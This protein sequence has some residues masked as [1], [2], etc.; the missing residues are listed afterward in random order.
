MQWHELFP[1]DKTPTTEDISRF[2]GGETA[3]L[4]NELVHTCQQRWKAK[5]KLTYSVC[6][7]KPG[8]NLKLQKSGK[9]LGT[10]YPE[11]GSFS[12]FMVLPFS[13]RESMQAL[14]P[15]LSNHVAGLW[16]KAEDFMKAGKWMMWSVSDRAGMEELL[17]IISLKLD[18]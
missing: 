3:Q 6:S 8:W 5:S 10:L 18:A 4:W 15:Q 17:R 2:I 12:V 9:T 1:K 7:G 16:S 13:A 14:L 11:S